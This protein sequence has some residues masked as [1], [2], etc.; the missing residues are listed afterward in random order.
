MF[1]EVEHLIRLCQGIMCS[2]VPAMFCLLRF[3]VEAGRACYQHC[4][5]G[6]AS[7]S[8]KWSTLNI[9][10]SMKG[11]SSRLQAEF[12]VH[13]LNNFI[14]GFLMLISHSNECIMIILIV[15]SSYHLEFGLAVC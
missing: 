6:T 7:F 11:I 14:I 10:N 5:V 9:A 15:I 13:K 3:F 8:R 12:Q 2:S 1:T 4:C